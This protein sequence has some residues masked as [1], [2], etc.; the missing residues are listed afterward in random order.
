MLKR[1]I[2]A[3]VAFP[4]IVFVLFI[5]AW[6]WIG[7]VVIPVLCAYHIAS[8]WHAIAAGVAIW[9]GGMAFLYAVGF[10]DD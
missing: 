2:G 10:F 1:F 9:W 8:V 7:W 5:T 4:V 3:L 6:V